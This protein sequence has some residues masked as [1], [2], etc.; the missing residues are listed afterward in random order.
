MKILN[1][2]FLCLFCW[3]P[4]FSATNI[5]SWVD[6]NQPGKVAAFRIHWG[7]NVAIV[8][9]PA[10]NYTIVSSNGPYSVYMIAVGTNSIFSDPSATLP[11]DVPLA[12][13]LHLNGLFQ[14]APFPSGPWITE[15]SAVLN[16]TYAE[17]NKFYRLKGTLIP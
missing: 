15:T 7:T 10:T 5:L 17:P 9:A 16:V 1:I 12:P 14:S 3:F 6:P 8:N 2:I 11:V 4:T 13:I